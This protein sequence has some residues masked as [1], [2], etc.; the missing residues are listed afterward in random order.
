MLFDELCRVVERHVPEL[1]RYMKAARIFRIECEDLPSTGDALAS[2]ERRVRDVAESQIRAALKLWDVE[3]LGEDNVRL[4]FDVVALEAAPQR[5]SK[6]E[7]V[8]VLWKTEDGHLGYAALAAETGTQPMFATGVTDLFPQGIMITQ[9]DRLDTGVNMLAIRTAAVTKDGLDWTVELSGPEIVAGWER[10]ATDAAQ[11]ARD[12]L[13]VGLAQLHVSSDAEERARIKTAYR[14]TLS[15][16]IKETQRS[17]SMLAATITYA[18]LFE[19]GARLLVVNTPSKF[20]VEEQPIATLPEPK[21]GQLVRSP[22]RPHY[23]VLD[24]VEIRSRY[25]PRVDEE[26][27]ARSLRAA[28]ERRGHFR[29]YRSEKFKQARG[30]RVWIDAMWVGPRE[31]VL[32]PNRYTVRLDL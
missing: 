29:T 10:V 25:L 15:E 27:P 2:A 30:R 32:G 13:E 22:W 12:K 1:K 26:A 5:H 3:E 23:I 9:T 24:P 18:L 17:R 7:T 28:H 14:P 8:V 31:A 20:I 11:A 4:P 16:V 21:P 6:G 19:A